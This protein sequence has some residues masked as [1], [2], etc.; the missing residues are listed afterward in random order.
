MK[1]LLKPLAEL[2]GSLSER[3]CEVP[4][5]LSV[6]MVL[7][8]LGRRHPPFQEALFDE[9]GR[10]KGFINVLVNGKRVDMALQADLPL[11]EGDEISLFSYVAGG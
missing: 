1:I 10:V 7:R 6:E 4:E 3:S 9:H 5:G 11:C 2:S 8:E